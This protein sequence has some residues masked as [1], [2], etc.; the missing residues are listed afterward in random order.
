MQKTHARYV[1]NIAAMMRFPFAIM[2]GDIATF[3]EMDTIEGE[4]PMLIFLR[5]VACA[6]IALTELYLFLYATVHVS[7]ICSMTCTVILL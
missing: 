7:I 2:K 5:F 1:I 6:T 3:A 4:D